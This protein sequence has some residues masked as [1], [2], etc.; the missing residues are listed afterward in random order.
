MLLYILFPSDFFP[1]FVVVEQIDSISTCCSVCSVPFSMINVPLTL[2]T[3][4]FTGSPPVAGWKVSH[5]PDMWLFILKF[6]VTGTAL[7]DDAQR[8]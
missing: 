6:A 8:L 4:L 5:L 2:I 3:S 7:S 1:F